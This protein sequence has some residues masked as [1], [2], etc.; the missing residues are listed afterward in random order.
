MVITSGVVAAWDGT[1]PLQLGLRLTVPLF[2]E[3]RAEA[4][5]SGLGSSCLGVEAAQC[6]F[7]NASRAPGLGP[8]QSLRM[9][10]ATLASWG[11]RG[12]GFGMMSSRPHA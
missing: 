8:R 1:A 9:C 3:G 2:L 12:L 5:G 10:R 11:H 6:P 7:L 4:Q